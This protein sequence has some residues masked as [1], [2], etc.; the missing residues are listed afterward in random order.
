MHFSKRLIDGWAIG[1]ALV[2]GAFGLAPSSTCAATFNQNLGIWQ[3]GAGAAGNLS[4]EEIQLVV[5][6][7]VGAL[8]SVTKP[9]QMR[10][11][12]KVNAPLPAPATGPAPSNVEIINKLLMPG[13]SD[14]DVPLPHPDL[15]DGGGEPR[16]AAGSA[17][18]PRIFGRSEQ[19]GGVFGLRIP[20]PAERH[21]SGANTRY[22]VDRPGS[23]AGPQT[24]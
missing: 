8:P 17:N 16:S 11:P 19:G 18:N 3:D 4:S 24:P 22:S 6:D 13:A 20:I 1:A 7:P 5:V 10:A 21:A 2:G 9:P 14:P 12:V 15:A 23:E